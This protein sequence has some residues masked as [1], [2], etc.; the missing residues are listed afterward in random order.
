MSRFNDAY[1]ERLDSDD[2]FFYQELWKETGKARY[3]DLGD[4]EIDAFLFACNGPKKRGLLEPRGTGKTT[5]IG[6]PLACRRLY[7]DAT[8]KIF[9]P[10]KSAGGAKDTLSMLREWFDKVWFLRHLAPTAS[11][12]DTS[13][14][15]DVNGHDGDRQPSIKTIGVDG[16]LEGN[17]AHTI[18]PDDC[19]TKGNTKTMEARAELERLTKEFDNILYLETPGVQGQRDPLE[20]VY[21]GTLKHETESL[22]IKLA[23]RNYAIRTYPII[24]PEPGRRVLGLAPMLQERLDRNPALAGQSIAL[25]RFDE[26][27]IAERRALGKI[28]FELEHALYVDVANVNKFPLKLADIIVHPCHRDLAPAQLVWGTQKSSGSTRLQDIPSVGLN[29]DGFYGP[30]WIDERQFLPYQKQMA[31]IDPAAGGADK[32]GLAIGASLNGMCFVKHVEGLAG[33]AS[34]PENIRRMAVLCKSHG[35]NTVSI[36]ANNGGVF[37]APLL[38]I[39]LQKVAEDKSIPGPPNWACS[40]DEPEHN[41]VQKEVRII[42][43]LDA[44]HQ[45]HRVVWDP[46]VARN[47]ELQ[48]QITRCTTERGCLGHDD[49]ADAL[50]GLLARLAD[51]LV[52]DPDRAAKAEDERRKQAEIDEHH[53]EQYGIQPEEP[54]YISY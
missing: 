20:I 31:R 22:Y 30:V 52:I 17:R 8:R 40:I 27:A 13:T 12:R 42:T 32:V 11:H 5:G 38:A 45:S 2:L 4:F 44:L 35:V 9:I 10:S 28:E 41:S 14:H 33:S 39:E 54:R 24:Y 46:S 47:E 23:R 48:R 19:E 18:I 37:L 6:A 15:F 26:T 3:G 34:K 1:L 25:R 43:T 29:T 21:L 36:E 16:M 7:R 53:R 49:E 50:E 51:T